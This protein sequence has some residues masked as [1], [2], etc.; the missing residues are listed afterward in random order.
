MKVSVIGQGRVGRALVRSL[1]EANIDVNAIGGRSFSFENDECDGDVCFFC[2]KDDVLK[3]FVKKCKG[4]KKTI[5]I[6]C[7]GSISSVEIFDG[8]SENYG[9]FY[10]LRSFTGDKNEKFSNTNVFVTGSNEYVVNILK[11]LSEKIGAKVYEL[12]DEKRLKLHL[13]AVFAHNFTNHIISISK[14]ITEETSVPF[15]VIIDLLKPYFEK[16]ISTENPDLLQTG[17][18]VRKDFVTMEKHIE[19]LKKNKDWQN[20]YRFVTE[21]ILKIIGNNE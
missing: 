12:S 20:I 14:A 18:A 9:V 3:N 13:A 19:L 11:K 21:S 7:S 15:S 17:P 16:L 2:L 6:H 8:V 10:P 1:V 5:L 4:I